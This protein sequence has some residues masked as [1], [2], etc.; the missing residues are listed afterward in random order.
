MPAFRTP[1]SGDYIKGEGKA[2]RMAARLMAV[3]ADSERG[4][5]LLPAERFDGG[6]RVC[7]EIIFP[8]TQVRR[9]PGEGKSAPTFG[10]QAIAMV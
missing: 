10:R 6:R 1:I 5:C 9:R 8:V 3:V 4:P 7:K 2:G